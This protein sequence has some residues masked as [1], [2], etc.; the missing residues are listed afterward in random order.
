MYHMQN[1][2][3]WH[4]VFREGYGN[5]FCSEPSTTTSASPS[6]SPSEAPPPRAKFTFIETLGCYLSK[7]WG[8][9]TFD[10]LMQLSQITF[11]DANGFPIPYVILSVAPVTSLLSR[12]HKLNPKLLSKWRNSRSHANKTLKNTSPFYR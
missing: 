9:D 12:Y 10:D 3:V 11:L 6:R 7:I 5:E 4:I 2:F 1:V 8:M